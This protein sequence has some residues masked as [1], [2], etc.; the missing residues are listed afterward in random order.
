MRAFPVRMPGAQEEGE[1][2]F[3][4]EPVSESVAVAV[5]PSAVRA[6]EEPVF[7]RPRQ[8][9]QLEER[10]PLGFVASAKEAPRPRCTNQLEGRGPPRP[11]Q[12]NQ[13]E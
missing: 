6:T 9:N 2:A 10:G 12:T 5:P 7:T 1:P 8:T 4:H 3:G 13:L 11:R